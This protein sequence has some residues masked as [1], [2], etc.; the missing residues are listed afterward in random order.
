M[1]FAPE[2]VHL[3]VN[4]TNIRPKYYYAD[5][6]QFF[7]R[8]EDKYGLTEINVEKIDMGVTL[9]YELAMIPPLLVDKGTLEFSCQDLSLNSVFKLQLNQTKLFFEVIVSHVLIQ[10]NPQKFNF[11]LNSYSDL[12]IFANKQTDLLI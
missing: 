7:M 9:D 2:N 10:I 12:T 6:A 3:K 11:K 4:I 8:R 1:I 5:P